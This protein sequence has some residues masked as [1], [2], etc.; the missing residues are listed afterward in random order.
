MWGSLFMM[1]TYERVDSFFSFDLWK[2]A[3]CLRVD[4]VCF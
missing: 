1:A 2:K 4:D 3:D